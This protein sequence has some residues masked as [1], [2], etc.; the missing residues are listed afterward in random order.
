M[1]AESSLTSG[2]GFL[3]TEPPTDRVSGS[4][5]I[6][7]L[8]TIRGTMPSVPLTHLTDVGSGSGLAL[9]ALAGWTTDGQC[10]IPILTGVDISLQCVRSFNT[11]M[12]RLTS[13]TET[14]PFTRCYH[15]DIEEC[16]ALPGSDGVFVFAA[17][18]AAKTKRHI[19][20]LCKQGD[21]RWLC[22]VDWAQNISRDGWTAVFSKVYQR[23]S[24]AQYTAFVSTDLGAIT[25][26]SIR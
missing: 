18:M 22:F 24:G 19:I 16:T 13:S 11:T 14:P 12:N 2:R 6:G 17:G 20:R 21:V 5:R 10:C 1:L 4:L 7:C 25:Q 3:A 9:C 26:N 8:A 15:G 23:G